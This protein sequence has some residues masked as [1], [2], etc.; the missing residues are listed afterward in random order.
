[1]MNNT[2]IKDYTLLFVGCI[3]NQWSKN[4]YVY[5]QQYSSVLIYNIGINDTE[6]LR[7]RGNEE[8]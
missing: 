8:L 2:V 4:S 7:E 1:M 5:T 3:I 6:Q